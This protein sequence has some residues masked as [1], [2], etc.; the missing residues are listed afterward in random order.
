MILYTDNAYAPN[1]RKVRIYLAEKGLT[2]EQVP[3]SMKEREHK[4]AAFLKMNSLGQLPVLQ[5]DDGHLISESLA[6]CRYL[7]A[8]H[9]TP[10]MFGVSALEIAMVEMWI[11]R[12][13]FRIWEPMR[14]A[15]RNDDERTEHIITTRF[16]AHGQY[17]R[18][19]VADA[20]R[21]V[22]SE[23]ADQ[24]PYIAGDHYSMADNV[25][26]CGIDFCKYVNMDMPAEAQHLLAWHQRVS[27][28]A[29]AAA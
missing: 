23:L 20:M 1:P 6:I 21:W 25:L 27:A 4:S 3:V 17:S 24:R 29:S 14:Q 12:A 26:L 18:S 10:P 16:K 28:R 9:P 22:D 7:E 5:T 19:V 11:K 15:W 2:V 13:E 8:L